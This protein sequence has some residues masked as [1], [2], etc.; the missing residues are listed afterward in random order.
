[1]HRQRSETDGS[2]YVGYF[3]SHV[4]GRAAK[5]VG[6]S[7]QVDLQF[8]HAEIGDADMAFVVQEDV[9][10]FQVSLDH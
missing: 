6:R 8:A 4:V 3:G 10:Q 5:R 1:M 7:V 2:K 9:V